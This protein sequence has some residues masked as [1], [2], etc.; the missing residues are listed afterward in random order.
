MGSNVLILAQVTDYVMANKKVEVPH[1]RVGSEF[2]VGTELDDNHQYQKW[3]S[4]RSQVWQWCAC[5][6]SEHGRSLR[7]MSDCG[8][9]SLGKAVRL[10]TKDV[11]PALS[12]ILG[13]DVTP[14]FL[15]HIDNHMVKLSKWLWRK[16][17]WWRL[18]SA[19]LVSHTSLC[20]QT[21]YCCVTTNGLFSRLQHW[22]IEM[23]CLLIWKGLSEL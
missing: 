11:S 22:M 5:N 21:K 9:V 12:L 2:S 17:C 23:P 1:S 16:G 6:S 8:L 3:A 19:R 4:V 10:G 7:S 18:V 14:Q 15:N 13:N 20:T